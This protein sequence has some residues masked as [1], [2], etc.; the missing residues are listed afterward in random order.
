MKYSVPIKLVNVEEKGTHLR[1]GVL[2]NGKQSNFIIDTGASQTVMDKTRALG[3]LEWAGVEESDTKIKGLGTDSMQSFTTTVDTLAVGDFRVTNQEIVLL[4][5]SHVIN[6]YLDMGEEPIDGVLGGDI[7]ASYS[8]V[9]D[10]GTR[11]I[12][13]TD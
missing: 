8:A 3:F 9:I 7:L 2:V 11:T 6:S 1:V 5:L 13:F 10:Y 12:D 4:D